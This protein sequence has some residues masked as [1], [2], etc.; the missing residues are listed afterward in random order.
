M[1]EAMT[2]TIEARPAGAE[3]HGRHRGGAAACEDS[4]APTRGRHRRLSPV[5]EQAA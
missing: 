3:G 2:N 5:E 1:S 4:A